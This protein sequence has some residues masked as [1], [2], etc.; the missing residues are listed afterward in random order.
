MLNLY[1]NA[2]A[3]DEI[4]SNT[5]ENIPGSVTWDLIMSTAHQLI[6]NVCN[7][8]FSNNNNTQYF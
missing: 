2:E 1:S 5:L 6:L 8:N 3:V 4:T 7:L